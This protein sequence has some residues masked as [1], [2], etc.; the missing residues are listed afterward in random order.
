MLNMRVLQIIFIFVLKINTNNN[1]NSG[2][3]SSKII[4]KF[5]MYLSILI[6]TKVTVSNFDLI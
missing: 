6:C 1:N 2:F 5:S 3:I 4:L